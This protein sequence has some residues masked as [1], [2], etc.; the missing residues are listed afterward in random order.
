MDIFSNYRLHLIAT[1]LFAIILLRSC[2]NHTTDTIHVITP[3]E[4]KPLPV[5]NY[6]KGFQFERTD[7]T[8]LLKILYPSTGDVADSLYVIHPDKRRQTLG[9]RKTAIQSTT[10]FAFFERLNELTSIVA[11]CGKHYLSREQ[12]EKAKNVTEI[13]SESGFNVE[14][15]ATLQP[16]F[17]LVYPFEQKDLARF[18][19]LGINT[20]LIT[21]YLEQTP[22]ARAEWLKLFGWMTNSPL[23][24]S[25]FE[26]IE[27]VYHAHIQTSI[28]ATVALNVPF[29][30]YW[31]MPNGN[32]ITAN[33]LKDAGLDY[34]F[35]NKLIE[36]NVEL[37]MEEAYNVLSKADYWV[38]ITERQIGFTMKDLLAENKIYATF[39][40]VQNGKVIFCNTAEN[41]YFS[42]GVIEP[43]IMLQDLVS[44][45]GKK[46]QTTNRYFRVLI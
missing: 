24:E 26:E 31:N 5:I 20:L 3:S 18:H 7:S 14:K 43:H 34:V 21:E 45:L 44:C 28:N 16:D 25:A 39:P 1:S 19:R 6:A 10:H 2:I 29:G 4:T 41:D 40:S 11:L 17:L 9:F 42:K 12:L 37:S 35:S 27:S 46:Q 38:I 8:L 30:E 36:G 23:L 22:L 13:C 15:I 33:L 32:S